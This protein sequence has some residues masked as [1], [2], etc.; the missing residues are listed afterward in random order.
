MGYSGY[1]NCDAI[2]IP[3]GQVVFNEVN[4]RIGGCTHIHDLA[5]RLFGDGYADRMTLLTRNKIKTGP[6]EEVLAVLDRE[7]LLYRA[8]DEEGVVILTEDTT[9]TGTIEYLIAAES[10]ADARDLERRTLTALGA[11]ALA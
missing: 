2:L 9:R 5:T 10:R 4:G 3:S 11:R 7:D 8:G 6:F 1:L